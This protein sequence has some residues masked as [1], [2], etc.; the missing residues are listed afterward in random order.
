[1]PHR[2]TISRFSRDILDHIFRKDPVSSAAIIGGGFSQPNSI[3]SYAAL[4]L[5]ARSHVNRALA[6]YRQTVDWRRTA[7]ARIHLY[8]MPTN[9]Q[10]RKHRHQDSFYSTSSTTNLKLLFPILAAI[11]QQPLVGKSMTLASKGAPRVLSIRP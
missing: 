9:Q 3:C 2:S 1:M 5:T 11:S 10:H 8:G 6:V 7:S 4:V